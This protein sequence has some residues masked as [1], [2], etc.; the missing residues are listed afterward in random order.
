MYYLCTRKRKGSPASRALSSK[1]NRGV[2]Q[3][4][5]VRVWGGVRSLVRV[6]LGPPPVERSKLMSFAAK[7]L[8]ALSLGACGYALWLKTAPKRWQAQPW[9]EVA[10]PA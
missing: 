4:V 5:R 9:V 3:L 8:I 2:A 6:Q 10:D 7:S 1:N